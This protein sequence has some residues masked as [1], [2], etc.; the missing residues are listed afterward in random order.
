MKKNIVL[1]TLSILVL[2]AS[3]KKD[4]L[5]RF[6]TD[7]YT[8]ES[9]WKTTSDA[10]AALNSCY[11]GWEGSYNIWYLDAVTDNL[12]SQ[13]WWEGYQDYGNG[14]VTAT[15]GNVYTRWD[16]TTIQRCNW[17]LANIDNVPDMDATLKAQYVGEARFIRAYQYFMLSQLYG[18][19]PYTTR[20][21]TVAEANVITRTSQD[22]VRNFVLD[23]LGD[24]ANVLPT[25]YSGSNIGRITKGAALSLKGRLELYMGKYADCIAD[26][27]TV[28][29]LGYTLY[30]SYGDLFSIQNEN[31][32]EVILD[33]QYMENNYSNGNV[34]I[35][36]SASFGGWASLDPTQSMVDAYE[37][38]NGKTIDQSGSGYDASQPFA[39]RDP[40]L[41]ASIV[42]PGALYE[43]K[44]YN[45]IQS[46]SGDYYLNGN[47]SPTGYIERKFTTNLS[48][49]ADMWN[50]GL[51][52]IVIRYAEVLLM[53]AE[54]KIEAGQIDNTVYTA[55]NQLRERAG[56]PDVDQSVYNSQSTL[57]TLV[58]RERRVELAFEGLRWFDIQRLK[59]GPDVRSG[60]V[61][62]T[63]LGTVNASTGAVVFTGA[64][65]H[66]ENRTFDAARDYLWPVP[67][68]EI[69]I[70]KNLTQNLNY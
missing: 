59:I 58:R 21:V 17:F 5:D 36:P 32:S 46:S 6:P 39:N 63:K 16:Y 1:L 47:C 66:V 37:M 30:P 15:D 13:F 23:E 12:Y 43:G 22:S 4:F 48:D 27:Q 49:Y 68:S 26:C 35:M 38:K 10:T 50:T 64:N 65:V 61:Y 55:I 40:R 42:Y 8:N 69:N 25:S 7:S 45:S 34:G 19:V 62:G 52:V 56:M 53:Y 54:A 67:Q 57:L 44:Y 51:N 24:I 18:A 28:M 31:N 29:G 14:S 2:F 9:L 11:D 33:I 20:Q 60:D 41:A 3:C 70:N